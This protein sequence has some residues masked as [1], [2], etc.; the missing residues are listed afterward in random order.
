MK[1]VEEGK[2][3]IQL[4]EDVFYNNVQEFN[5]DLSIAVISEF[6]K[7]YLAKRQADGLVILEGLSATGLRAIRYAK[8]IGNVQQ[9]CANDLDPAAFNLINKNIEQN[10]VGGK[11]VGAN[12][13]VGLLMATRKDTFDVID[14][15][16]YGSAAPFIE[17]AV[18]SVRDGGLLCV[19]CTDGAVLCGK[20]PETA[21]ARYGGTSFRTPFSHE[22][23]IRL[24]LS[25]L[26]TAAGRHKKAIVP[27]LS[28]AIDFYVR[29]FV[30]V[31]S[32]PKKA[33]ESALNTGP[34][35][36]CPSCT[37][38]SLQTH[39]YANQDRKGLIEC[40]RQ[41]C[42]DSCSICQTRYRLC[43]PV[44]QGRLHDKGFLSGMD[45]QNSTLG[46]K[47]RIAGMVA[48]ALE[49]LD[50]PF[51]VS[52]PKLSGILS[53]TTPSTNDFRCAILNA[54]EYRVSSTH[55]EPYGVKT[56]APF[57][58]IWSIMRAH[59]ALHPTKKVTELHR[60]IF[61]GLP[62]M[63]ISFEKRDDAVSDAKRRKLVRYQANPEENWGPKPRAG[64]H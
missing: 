55:T 5:R 47:K 43:G 18:Q 29:V 40:S 30:V 17:G 4:P 6:Q 41:P 21:F 2:A 39:C 32:S 31:V 38:F 26:S 51:F 11:V 34:V 37:S 61:S 64:R 54:G 48:L 56:D 3:A 13:D 63:E 24:V 12:E 42:G 52:M 58:V 20:N 49:E 22:M 19:T 36:Y 27:L 50:T 8:E 16:P 35:F 14:L 62:P 33:K 57:D 10:G 60:K 15:D 28:L 23:G 46:T 9:V 53:C 1:T 44:W 7:E 59:V 45:T 25:S